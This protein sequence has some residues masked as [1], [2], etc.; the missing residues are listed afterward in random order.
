MH[1]NKLITIPRNEKKINLFNI[2]KNL[3]P[4]IFYY[5]ND[6]K[7][8]RGVQIKFGSYYFT[9]FPLFILIFLFVYAC[10]M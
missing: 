9:I 6:L 3:M 10:Y 2:N 4:I 5:R 8:L 7:Y 1:L